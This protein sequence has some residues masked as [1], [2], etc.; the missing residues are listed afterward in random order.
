M[1]LDLYLAL[2]YISS[3]YTYYSIPTQYLKE[4]A[5]G[6]SSSSQCYLASEDSVPYRA[7]PRLY[8]CP[9]RR[10]ALE[11]VVYTVSAAKTL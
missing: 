8:K 11:Y 3:T 4:R 2:Y 7:G 9:G 6:S 5:A 1:R 10:V